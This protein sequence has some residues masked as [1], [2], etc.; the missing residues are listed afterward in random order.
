MPRRRFRPFAIGICLLSLLGCLATAWLARRSYRPGGIRWT[1]R[2]NDGRYTVRAS[3][4]E[5]IVMRPPA[6][7]SPADVAVARAWL[8]SWPQGPVA[9]WRVVRLDDGYVYVSPERPVVAAGIGSAEV[10]RP[11]LEALEDP[12]TFVTAHFAL[13]HSYV[14]GGRSDPP[15][16]PETWT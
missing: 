3:R 1:V 10:A 4:G 15:S 2:H 8:K 11:L 5:L 13:T 12:D 9:R 7:G 14:P 16:W 6:Y